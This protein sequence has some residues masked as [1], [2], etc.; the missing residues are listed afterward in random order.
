MARLEAIAKDVLALLAIETLPQQAFDKLVEGVCAT[1]A[2]MHAVTRSVAHFQ[3]HTADSTQR[4]E[5]PDCDV[6]RRCAA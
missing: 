3:W 4:G 5:D 6:A 2:A 1:H